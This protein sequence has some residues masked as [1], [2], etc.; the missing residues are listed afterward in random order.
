MVLC[1]HW[2][3]ES[4]GSYSPFSSTILRIAQS[5]FWLKNLDLVLFCFDS[6]N[7]MEKKNIP[8]ALNFARECKFEIDDSLQ[9]PLD[10]YFTADLDLE[11]EE[12]TN[13][14]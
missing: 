14:S 13:E 6:G 12:N 5:L 9:N 4:K 2:F 10:L 11:E 1:S 8:G 3:T 7:I